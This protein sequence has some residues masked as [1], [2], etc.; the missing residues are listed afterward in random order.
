MYAPRPDARALAQ[1]R[2]EAE[3][4]R[5]ERMAHK[6][7]WV[8]WAAVVFCLVVS[9]DWAL[10]MQQFSGEPML[11]KRLVSVGSY[12]SNPQM[13]YRI[14]T[15]H[16]RFK[17]RTS[18]AYRIREATHLTVWRTPLLRVVQLIK[19]P[20]VAAGREP[21][22]PYRGS[23]YNSLT[24]LF[25]V[26]LLLTAGVGLLLPFEPETRLNTAIVSGLLWLVTLAIMV[27]F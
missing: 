19:A 7:R 27:L 14:R 17:L 8:N 2:R 22:V 3:Y 26:A 20:S 15:P 18:Q 10:P 4:A 6:A 24:V 11:E 12:L 16:T 9:L 25:P 21:F 5:M 1:Q 23:I 13:A